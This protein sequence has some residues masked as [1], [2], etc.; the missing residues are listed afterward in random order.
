[1]MPHTKNNQAIWYPFRSKS[2]VPHTTHCG[3]ARHAKQ[4]ESQS[5]MVQMY[6][7]HIWQQS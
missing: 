2:R 1:M 5:E 4:V 7:H 6:L 3:T